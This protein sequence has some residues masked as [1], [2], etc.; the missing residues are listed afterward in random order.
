M[1]GETFRLPMPALA[2]VAR[3]RF[4]GKSTAKIDIP[5]RHFYV[6]IADAANGSQKSLHKLF[7]KYLDHMLVEFE[8]NRFGPNH[9]K[10][11]ASIDWLITAIS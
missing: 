7:G 6:T 2:T 3:K 5:N 11:C 1:Y 4:N 10:C 9:T 8:Q